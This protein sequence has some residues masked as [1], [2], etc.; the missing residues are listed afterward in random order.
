[1]RYWATLLLLLS[2]CLPVNS[3]WALVPMSDRMINEAVAYGMENQGYG[4]SLFMGNNWREG[5]NGAL[6][7]IYTPYM[8]LARSAA[9]RKLP[10]QVT[11]TT[12][13]EARKK[14]VED[15]DY[16]WQHP[17]V[18]FMVSMYGKTPHFAGEYYA[19]IEG[20][21]KG[22]NYTLYPTRRMPQYTADL[23]KGVKESPYTA[24]NAYHFKYEDIAPLDE[25]V[26]KLYGKDLEPIRFKVVNRDI[27]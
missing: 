7:N 24:I 5:A 9:T 22:R 17:T 23:D 13:A 18:K 26:L 2:A 6:L 27:K 10:D 4:M 20:V 12:L 3:T 14:M 8:E 1:M 19:V 25:Y 21:G 16:I 15:I 11:P